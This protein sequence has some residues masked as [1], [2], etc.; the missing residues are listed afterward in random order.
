MAQP[1]AHAPERPIDGIA[2]VRGIEHVIRERAEDATLEF[3]LP[4]EELGRADGLAARAAP[5]A[6]V[7]VARDADEVAA[8]AR[9]DE[10]AREQVAPRRAGGADATAPGKLGAHGF[11]H[12]ELHDRQLGSLAANPFLRGPVEAAPLAALV[13]LDPERAIPDDLAAVDGV[14][15]DH[16]DGRGRPRGP[17]LAVGARPGR[18]DAACVERVRELLEPLPFQVAREDRAHDGGLLGIYGERWEGGV[19]PSEDEALA[20][21]LHVICLPAAVCE[22][23]PLFLRLLIARAR[24]VPELAWIALDPLGAFLFR[25]DDGRAMSLI[26]PEYGQKVGN[27]AAQIAEATG[28]CVTPVAHMTR[29]SRR[30][31][32]EGGEA[33]REIGRAHV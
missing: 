7:E 17:A 18:C 12:R 33:A 15:K 4:H 19:D 21:F 30:S 1:C 22:F 28:A 16:A 11:A 3:V 32:H 8:A 20:T 9:A 5:R 29:A 31:Q 10:Q 13:V 2:D 6:S 26:A 14:Q 27:V 24:E 25:D 23:D